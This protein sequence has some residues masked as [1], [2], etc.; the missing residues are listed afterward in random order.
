M[1][2]EDINPQPYSSNIMNQ[3]GYSKK[4]AGNIAAPEA[5][6]SILKYSC[7]LITMKDMF[8]KFNPDTNWYN[9]NCHFIDPLAEK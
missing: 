1:I 3:Q 4:H 8:R 6:S 5:T 7:F 9:L 2:V